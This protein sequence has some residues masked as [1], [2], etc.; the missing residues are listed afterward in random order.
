MLEKGI[1]LKPNYL[2]KIVLHLG[3]FLPAFKTQPQCDSHTCQS[4]M[5]WCCYFSRHRADGD[6]KSSHQWSRYI[7]TMP[8][9]ATPHHS[10][11][12]PWAT[13]KLAC[14]EKYRNICLASMVFKSLPYNHQASSLGSES[15]VA[16][17]E[18]FMEV[19]LKTLDICHVGRHSCLW[20]KRTRVRCQPWR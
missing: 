9:P 16:P 10:Q 14:K 7:C 18:E 1:F 4:S 19:Y 13:V 6:G 15:S 3:S 2:K 17:A 20:K 5:Q 12:E 8:V 11:E